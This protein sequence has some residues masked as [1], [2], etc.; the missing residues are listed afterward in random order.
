MPKIIPELLNKRYRH[1]LLFCCLLAVVVVGLGA[2]TRLSDAGLGCPDWP[3]CYGSLVPQA[4]DDAS[5]SG[6]FKYEKA[7][8]EMIHRYSAAALG[9]SI[10]MLF[11]FSIYLRRSSK[12]KHKVFPIRLPALLLVLVGFQAVLGMLTVTMS[13]QPLIVMG[14]LL[15]GFAIL[16]L[17]CLLYLRVNNLPAGTDNPAVKDCL[18][19]SLWG[20]SVLLI[21][22]SLGGWLAANYAAPYCSGLPLCSGGWNAGSWQQDFSFFEIFQLPTASESYEY[23]RLSGVARL[24]IHLV[25]RFWA[26]FT[27]ALLL[28]ISIRIYLISDSDKV[29]NCALSVTLIVIWQVVLGVFLVYLHF[30]VSIA[31]A[32]NLTAALL[33]VSLIRLIYYLNKLPSLHA[34]NKPKNSGKAE[35]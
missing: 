19:G 23:G 29:K 26:V 14:H 13:L 33:L 24:S 17:L 34:D 1:L 32:H 6:E 21:Q 27:A 2:Y 3:G 18:S 11:L 5:F 28:F 4:P 8:K 25:H 7:W 30:P 10:F 9:L 35:I 12:T 20:L 15:G 31:L 16:S 22:I